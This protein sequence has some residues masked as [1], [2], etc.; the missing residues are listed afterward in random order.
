MA[1]IKIKVPD[2]IERELDELDLDISKAVIKTIKE[3][4]AKF[5]ILRNLSLKSRITEEDTIELGRKLKRGR[6]N[7]LKKRGFI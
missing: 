6:F 2:S 3:E 4:L 5:I 1:E 7:E